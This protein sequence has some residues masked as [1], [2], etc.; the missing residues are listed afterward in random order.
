M[1]RNIIWDLDGTIF[2]TYPGFITGFENA[3]HTFSCRVA[4]EEIERLTRISITHCIHELAQQCYLDADEL[5]TAFQIAYNRVSAASQRPFPGVLDVCAWIQ[6]QGGSNV[7][8]THRSR[9]GTQ[10]LLQVHKMADL[11]HDTIAGDEG[12]ARKPDPEAFL[13]MLARHD[14]KPQETLAAGDRALDV[15][16]GRSAG[17]RT[18]AFLSAGEKIDA[19][20]SVQDYQ[21]LLNWLIENSIS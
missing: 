16:A 21:L 1:I 6:A 9:A 8:V 17:L 10:E 2:D 20:L 3:L 15:M 12:F 4:R 13:E 18:C 14:F 11:F 19:D 5:R 7:I